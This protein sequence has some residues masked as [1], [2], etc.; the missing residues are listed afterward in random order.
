ML[1]TLQGASMAMSRSVRPFVAIEQNVRQ[2]P[3]AL[4]R[5]G[6]FAVGGR[7]EFA[8]SRPGE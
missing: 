4:R 6:F 7:Q 1:E 2:T 5:K 8:D 3:V